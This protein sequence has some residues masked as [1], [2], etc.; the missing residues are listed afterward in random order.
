MVQWQTKIVLG[1]ANFGNLYGVANQAG[2]IQWPT[3]SEMMDEAKALGVSGVDTAAAYGASEEV[4]GASGIEGFA[5][6]TKLPKYDGN[7]E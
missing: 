4:L 6:Q 3:A 7:H 5:I 1:T 2:A